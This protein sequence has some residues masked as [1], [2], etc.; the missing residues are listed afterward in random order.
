[1]DTIPSGTHAAELNATVEDLERGLSQLPLS[2]AINRIDDWQRE[3]RATEREDL[4]PIADGLEELHGLLVGEDLDGAAIGD[5]MVSLGER[6]EAAADGADAR[7]QNGLKRLGSL[8]RH[9]GGALAGNARHGGG[10]KP[11]GSDP[12]PDA[13]GSDRPPA[14]P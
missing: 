7:L 2:K 1:M 4:L 9:A 13:A 5:L 8:L 14:L 10:P 11:A 6:T 3:I 12:G